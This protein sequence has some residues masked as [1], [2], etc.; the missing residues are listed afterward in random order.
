[1]REK[2]P[3][4]HRPLS[5]DLSRCRSSRSVVGLLEQLRVWHQRYTGIG[6]VNCISNLRLKAFFVVWFLGRKV[7][8]VIGELQVKASRNLSSQEECSCYVHVG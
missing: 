4:R 2:H 7:A 1:M 5:L 3:W 8:V 6:Q